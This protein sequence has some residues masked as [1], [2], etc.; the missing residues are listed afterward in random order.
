MA[1]WGIYVGISAER[2][3]M[4]NRC[5]LE[6]EASNSKIRATLLVSERWAA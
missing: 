1:I 5:E 2:K 6:G 3:Y 4:K